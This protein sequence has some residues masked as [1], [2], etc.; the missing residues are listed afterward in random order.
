MT[1]IEA[2]RAP[3][4]TLPV[5]SAA[6]IRR[7]AAP[8][9]H[10]AFD[11]D[12]R[13]H[14]GHGALGSIDAAYVMYAVGMTPVPELEDPVRAQLQSVK[15]AL[16]PWA[17]PQMF[18]NL[19]ETP[20]PPGAFWTGQTLHRLRRIKTVVD[21]DELIRANHPIPPLPPGTPAAAVATRRA[22]RPTG[23]DT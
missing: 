22:V 8:A 10:G 2:Q 23:R 19:T 18:A 9:T 16:G 13:P 1:D 17:A 4:S 20:Q 12:Q 7:R 6:N 11:P 14:P 3:N 15:A 5:S 21:P